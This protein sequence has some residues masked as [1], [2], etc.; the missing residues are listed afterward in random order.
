M[1]LVQIDVVHLQAAQAFL[2]FR[3]DMPAREAD[4]I[5][6]NGFAHENIG[7][8]ADFCGDDQIFTPIAENA[9]ENFFRRTR[10]INIGGI[11]EIAAYFYESIE[12]FSCCFFVCFSSKRHAS[13]TKLGNFESSSA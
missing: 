3:H 8:E 5:G 9:P 7:V 2:D 4:L 11:E 1:H 6:R 13:K 12:N 10:R